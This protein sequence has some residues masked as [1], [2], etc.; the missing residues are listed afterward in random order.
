MLCSTIKNDFLFSDFLIKLNIKNAS[1]FASAYLPINF[2]GSN[3]VFINL[4]QHETFIN[5]V[6]TF[7][8]VKY[9]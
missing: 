6:T 9:K 3:S 5:D 1:V 7:S 2:K 4:F 8:I